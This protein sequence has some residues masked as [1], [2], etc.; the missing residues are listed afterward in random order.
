VAAGD[1]QERTRWA[2]R[3]RNRRTVDPTALD[4]T[5][6]VV[7]PTTTDGQQLTR[8]SDYVRSQRR[9]R[10]STQMLSVIQQL[11]AATDPATQKELIDWIAQNCVDESR[12]ELLGLFA[13]CYLGHPYVDHQMS[14]AHQILRHFTPEDAVPPAF[15]MA[16]SLVRSPAYLFVEVYGD[17]S[18]IPVRSNGDPVI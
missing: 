3:T 11:D 5:A 6:K 8:T 18:V 13:K 15:A 10:R 4:Q 9:L 16:R 7:A 1:D 12:G 2:R 17:G 14:L